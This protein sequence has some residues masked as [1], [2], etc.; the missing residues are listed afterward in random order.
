MEEQPD[1]FYWKLSELPKDHIEEVV[2]GV[3]LDI[4]KNGAVVGI[5]ISKEACEDGSCLPK[6]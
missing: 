4:S 1:G 3:V 6:E 2:S 5:K